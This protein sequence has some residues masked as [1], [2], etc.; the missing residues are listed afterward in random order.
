MH[1]DRH[2]VVHEVVLARHRVEYAAHA[3]RLFLRRNPLVAEVRVFGHK[4]NRVR[5]DFPRVSAEA[6]PRMTLGSD[7]FSGMPAGV[8][9]GAR[10][11]LRARVTPRPPAP[12]APPT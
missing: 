2:Q 1:T 12:S 11:G 5:L 7:L 6:S 4:K 3:T 9:R 10:Q 8:R